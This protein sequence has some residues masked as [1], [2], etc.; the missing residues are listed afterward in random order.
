MGINEATAKLVQAAQALKEAR[1]EAVRLNFAIDDAGK[2][3]VHAFEDYR[4]AERE[5]FDLIY[6][7]ANVTRE[8]IAGT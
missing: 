8:E 2:K 7:D 4:N 3:V 1:G 6:R 5:L